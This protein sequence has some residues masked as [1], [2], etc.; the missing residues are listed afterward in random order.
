MPRGWATAPL[1]LRHFPGGR[2][3]VRVLQEG[4][5]HPQPHGGTRAD[6]SIS[7]VQGPEGLTV[8]VDTGGPWGGSRLLGSLRELGVS[9][10]DVTH[11]VCSHGHSD[12]AG[13]INLFPT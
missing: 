11:V 7:L 12:H 6:G 13:N 10:E 1:G 2:F 9:P 5:S 4:F 8:L 3:G